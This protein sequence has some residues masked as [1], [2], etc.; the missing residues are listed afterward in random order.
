M[1]NFLIGA[2]IV[3]AILVALGKWA[4]DALDSAVDWDWDEEWPDAPDGEWEDVATASNTDATLYDLRGKTYT[5]NRETG[6]YHITGDKN[7]E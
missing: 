2:T 1:R 5:Y 4:W 6:H 3:T 7:H